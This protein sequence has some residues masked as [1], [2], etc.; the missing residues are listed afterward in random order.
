MKTR[1]LVIILAT[2]LATINALADLQSNHYPFT[3]SAQNV[4][5][6][7]EKC[8]GLKEDYVING[9]IGLVQNNTPV[10]IIVYYPNGTIYDS[11]SIPY[12]D[13]SPT[14][15]YKYRLSF[16]NDDK[17]AFGLY[18]ITI[19]YNGQNAHTSIYYPVVP[20]GPIRNIEDNIKIVDM[21]GQNLISIRAGQQVQIQDI[22]EPVCNTQFVYVMQIVDKNQMTDSLSWIAGSN[23]N[24]PMNFSQTWIQFYPGTYTINRFVWQNLTNPNSLLPPSY[25]TI[26]VG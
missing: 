8:G 17:S 16:M 14:G 4:S 21:N 22:L 10:K 15:N 25:K 7:Y 6:A 20:P 24:E 3:I 18:N 9:T 5:I 13:I 19:S 11:N 1:Y 12:E 26:E 23:L 2:S